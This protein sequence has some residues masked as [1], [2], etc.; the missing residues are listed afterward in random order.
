VVNAFSAVR[1]R[2]VVQES[3]GFVVEA[4]I[5]RQAADA[6][7]CERDRSIGD[8]DVAMAICMTIAIRKQPVTLTIRVP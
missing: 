5:G 3:R 7:D 4:G 2:A 1:S 6:S 8:H